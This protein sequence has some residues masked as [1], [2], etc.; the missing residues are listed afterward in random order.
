MQKLVYFYHTDR[1][2]KGDHGLKYYVLCEEI[3]KV[4]TNRY[5]RMKGCD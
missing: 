1:V 4:V 3:V 2:S 5:N